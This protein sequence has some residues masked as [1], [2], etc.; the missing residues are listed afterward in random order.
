MTGCELIVQMQQVLGRF[1]QLL[2]RQGTQKRDRRA[3]EQ[4][5]WQH[6]EVAQAIRERDLG[7]ARTMMRLQYK[8]FVSE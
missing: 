1:F 5:A 6:I 3:N 8:D 7:R 2:N 4:A